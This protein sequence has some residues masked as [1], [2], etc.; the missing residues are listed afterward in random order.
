MNKDILPDS[1][2]TFDFYIRELT[3]QIRSPLNNIINLAE[4]ALRENPAD[5]LRNY[6]KTMERYASGLLA[7]LDDII[8]DVTQGDNERDEEIREFSTTFLLDELRQGLESLRPAHHPDI[9]IEIEEPLPECFEGRGVKLRQV[10]VRLMDFSIRRA[11]AS[12]FH[13][14]LRWEQKRWLKFSIELAGFSSSLKITHLETDPGL[15]LCRGLLASLS[16][17]LNTSWGNDYLSL[18]FAVPVR[19]LSKSG[20]ICKKEKSAHLFPPVLLINSNPFSRVIISRRLHIEGMTFRAVQSLEKG[21]EFL[22]SL[23]EQKI[24]QAI[25]ILYWDDVRNLNNFGI[26]EMVSAFADNDIL[27][28]ITDIPAVEMMTISVPKQEE[29]GNLRPAGFV[30]KPSSSQAILM[31]MARISGLDPEKCFVSTGRPG[32]PPSEASMKKILKNRTALVIEDDRINQK[33]LLEILK[34]GGIKPVVASTGSA[35]VKALERRK[36]DAIFMDIRLPDCDGFE[37]TQKIRKIRTSAQ[38]PIIAITASSA[39]RQ[40]CFDAGM[41]RFLTKPY[42]EEAILQ[43]MAEVLAE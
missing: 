14:K 39:N 2:D 29:T 23:V 7:L 33:I 8:D 42:S 26:N 1:K 5:P 12:R 13:L 15:A 41:S 19:S 32:Q 27:A 20:K 34:N 43:T 40:R 21:M 31:E 38:T 30:M 22:Q 18:S 11:E 3:H 10:L 6:V 9:D 17:T 37:L 4:L 24:T 36:F 25:C 16:S 28:L 35:A